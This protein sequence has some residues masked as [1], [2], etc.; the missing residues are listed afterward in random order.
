MLDLLAHPECP[1]CG[2]F[3]RGGRLCSSCRAELDGRLH[4]APTTG[5]PFGQFWTGGAYGGPLGAIVRAAKFGPDVELAELIAGAVARRLPR[6]D[7]PWNALVAVPTTP[8]RRLGRGFHLPDLI[9]AAV[10]RSTGVPVR[11]ALHR[12]WG[13]SQS[14]REA[15]ARSAAAAALLTCR[16]GIDGRVLLI[17]DV[18]TT[19]ATLHVAAC[20]LRAAGA[21]GVDGL[22][23]AS[24]A[25]PVGFS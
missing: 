13:A 22:V 20:E 21:R 6:P 11:R 23:V 7:L 4:A 9:A 10:S 1:A 15:S 14:G 19:G 16:E 5:T 25:P 24:S 8:W 3:S 17:D 18:L 2:A 12:R